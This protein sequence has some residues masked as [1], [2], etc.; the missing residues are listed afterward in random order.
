M[1]A[2]IETTEETYWATVEGPHNVPTLGVLAS[3][4]GLFTPSEIVTLIAIGFTV[5]TH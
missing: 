2:A 1:T 4:V 3:D 5:I